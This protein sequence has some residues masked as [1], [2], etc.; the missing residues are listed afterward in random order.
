MQEY[1]SYVFFES[2]SFD[3]ECSRDIYLYRK[4]DF[5]FLSVFFYIAIAARRPL[6]LSYISVFFISQSLHSFMLTNQ[7]GQLTTTAIYYWKNSFNNT[8]KNRSLHF[9]SI[10]NIHGQGR[11]SNSLNSGFAELHFHKLI[12]LTS[13]FL[14]G[15]FSI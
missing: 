13:S 11:V 5:F 10:S 2:E 7:F 3:S 9:T 1:P 4:S 15:L 12:E 8:A 6:L 14:T